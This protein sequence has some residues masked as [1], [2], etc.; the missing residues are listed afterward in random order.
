M[1]IST[2]GTPGPPAVDFAAS[3]ADAAHLGAWAEVASMGGGEFSQRREDHPGPVIVYLWT[4]WCLPYGACE[5]VMNVLSTAHA[6]RAGVWKVNVEDEPDLLRALG[7]YGFPNVTA[8]Q[9]DREGAR[10]AGLL[11]REDQKRLFDAALTE[12]APAKA[13]PSPVSRSAEFR[14]KG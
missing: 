12:V 2:R 14:P 4:A 6:G 8:H 3:R 9:R 1:P 10:Q 7:V 13:I 5:P 11:S